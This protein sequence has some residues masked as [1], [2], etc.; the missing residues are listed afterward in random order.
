M[1]KIRVLIADDQAITRSGLKALLTSLEH[2][3]V[4]GEASNGEEAVKPTD[5]AKL[6]LMALEAGIG[7]KDIS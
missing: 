5:R 1:E 7:Q 4:I 6:M 3:A 2:T